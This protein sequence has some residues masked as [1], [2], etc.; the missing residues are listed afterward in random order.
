[1]NIELL[2]LASYLM[3]NPVPAFEDNPFS[4]VAGLLNNFYSS[5]STIIV[6]LGVL[7]I[8]VVAIKAIFKGTARGFEEMRMELLIIGGALL[9]YYLAPIIVNYIAS[10]YPAQTGAIGLLESVL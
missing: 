2:K 3:T 4:S 5:L 1:M 10:L 6:P 9:I 8:A 7:A